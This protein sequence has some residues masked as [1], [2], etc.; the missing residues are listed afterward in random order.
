[1]TPYER[2]QLSRQR[3]NATFPLP[4]VL[5]CIRYAIT[6]LAE[7]DDALLRA[8]RT[9]D[10]RNNGKEH[11]PRSELGQALYMLLSAHIQWGECPDVYYYTPEPGK[12]WLNGM[13]YTGTMV[14]LA[15]LTD[16]VIALTSPIVP[17]Y[18]REL[19]VNVVGQA[20]DAYNNMYALAMYHKW[21]VDTLVDD[22]CNRFEQKHT[23]QEAT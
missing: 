9:G 15:R 5:D 4:S 17:E 21:D 14:E 19:F 2:V 20:E 13:L 23:Q 8:E 18:E 3:T 22:T 16:Y 6:E 7:Y 1:M 11:D 12:E 10:K